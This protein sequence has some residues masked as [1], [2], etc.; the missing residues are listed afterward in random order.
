MHTYKSLLPLAAD[1]R[2]TFFPGWCAYSMGDYFIMPHST[3]GVHPL[4]TWCLL[5]TL[6]FFLFLDLCT[7]TVKEQTWFNDRLLFFL[8]NN[9]PEAENTW[10]ESAEFTKSSKR[11]FLF[12]LKQSKPTKK[13]HFS[14]LVS[15]TSITHALFNQFYHHLNSYF[16]CLPCKY[17]PQQIPMSY[18]TKNVPHIRSWISQLLV[19]VLVQTLAGDLYPHTALQS[20]TLL[21]FSI[22]SI[23]LSPDKHWRK[24]ADWGPPRSGLEQQ[25]DTST[26]GTPEV[27]VCLWTALTV[28]PQMRRISDEGTSSLPK[29]NLDSSRSRFL[30]HSEAR[31]MKT[32]WCAHV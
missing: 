20:K 24:A 6:L 10:L 13:K 4:F 18:Q 28:F 14:I 16:N 17:D 8:V 30:S 3:P 19:L 21:S 2:R 23:F 25:T 15:V 9:H 32:W 22:R 31:K 29:I 12:Y 1:T 7:F 5:G 11:L 26:T 27:F